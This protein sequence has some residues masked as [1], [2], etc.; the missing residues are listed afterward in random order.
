M[1]LP[2]PGCSHHSWGSPATSARNSMCDDRAVGKSGHGAVGSMSN[3]SLAFT[4]LPDAYSETT[5]V[6]HNTVRGNF[7]HL[8]YCRD[9]SNSATQKWLSV[10]RNDVVRQVLGSTAAVVLLTACGGFERASGAAAL[11]CL[12]LLSSWLV[13]PPIHKVHGNPSRGGSLHPSVSGPSKPCI[14][15]CL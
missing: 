6:L 2:P 13:V 7:L 11:S 12:C 5:K 3:D 1:L 10:Q 4:I 8:H 9:H 14:C 15:N